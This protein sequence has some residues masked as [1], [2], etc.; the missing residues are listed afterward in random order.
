[1]RALSASRDDKY[2]ELKDYVVASTGLA[3]YET[4]DDDFEERIDRRLRSLGLTNYGTYLTLLHDGVL[5]QSELDH[6]IAEL[7]IGET[8]FFRDERQFDVLRGLIMPDLLRRNRPRKTMRIWSAGCASGAEAYSLSVVLQDEFRAQTAGWDISILG[9]DVNRRLLTQAQS[10]CYEKWALRSTPDEVRERCFVADGNHWR[11]ADRYKQG[12]GFQYHNLVK[13]QTPSW[14]N[15]LFSFDLI[16]C[17]NV[18]IY[19]DRPTAAAVVH[20]LHDCLVPQAWLVVGHADHDPNTFRKFEAVSQNGV[21]V[22]R[23][24]GGPDVAGSALPD[25]SAQAFAGNPVLAAA[26]TQNGGGTQEVDPPPALPAAD[27]ATSS[28]GRPPERFLGEVRSLAD[29]GAWAKAEALCSGLIEEGPL[30]P[31]PHFYLALILEQ[32]GRFGEAEK[33]LRRSVYLDRKFVLAHYH[34]GLLLVR[35]GQQRAARQCFANAL[36]LLAGL[37]ETYVFDHGDGICAADLR[38]LTEMNLEGLSA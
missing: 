23:K 16:L 3:Y 26:G 38:D 30:D 12:V 7:T 28:G 18:M 34:L 36:T 6:L 25:A 37:H 22:Y 4:R 20:R 27:P 31:I 8:F 1:M 35:G 2:R 24:P 11:I 17:R 5:G 19:F 21:S 14:L 10:G 15:G 13:H 33:S 9:T 32:L 29:A